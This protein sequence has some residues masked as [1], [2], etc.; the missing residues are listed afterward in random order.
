M[1]K[2]RMKRNMMLERKPR[3]GE[4]HT[5]KSSLPWFNKLW[6][7]YIVVLIHLVSLLLF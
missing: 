5:E 1:K 6:Q 7:N 2:L 4:L 3:G